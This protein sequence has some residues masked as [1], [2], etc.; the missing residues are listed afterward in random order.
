MRVHIGSAEYRVLDHGASIRRGS[1]EA[2]KQL[3][4]ACNVGE[5]RL[6]HL[7][8]YDEMVGQ[9]EGGENRLEVPTGAPASP[10]AKKM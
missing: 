7:S 10:P 3:L 5:Y 6:V 9:P 2:L 1:A 4:A 8:A